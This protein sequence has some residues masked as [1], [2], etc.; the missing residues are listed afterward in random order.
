MGIPADLDLPSRLDLCYFTNRNLAS[1]SL[2]VPAG[3]CACVFVRPQTTFAWHAGY[4]RKVTGKTP[5][6]RLDLRCARKTDKF[7]K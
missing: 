7:C 4:D 2:R 1:S 5:E 6:E 3:V